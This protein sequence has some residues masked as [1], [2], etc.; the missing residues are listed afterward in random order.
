MD[1]NFAIQQAGGQRELADILGI[2]QAAVS[3]WGDKIP[4]Q[5]IWQLRVVKPEWFLKTEQQESVG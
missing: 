4:D 5:R 2:S 3:Q 1:K